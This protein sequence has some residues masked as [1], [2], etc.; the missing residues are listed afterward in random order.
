M[1]HSFIDYYKLL[2]NIII[3]NKI[4]NIFLKMQNCAVVLVPIMDQTLGIYADLFPNHNIKI[5]Q[6]DDRI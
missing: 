5:V 3:Q 1:Q 6:V 4:M 2:Y